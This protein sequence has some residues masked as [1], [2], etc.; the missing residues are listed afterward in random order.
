MYCICSYPMTLRLWFQS[1]NGKYH[2]YITDYI[3]PDEIKVYTDGK[4]ILG[5]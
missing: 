4:L 3:S 1:D 5:G 2:E